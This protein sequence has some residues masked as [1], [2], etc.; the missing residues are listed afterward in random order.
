MPLDS[1]LDTLTELARE[2]TDAAARML[3]HCNRQ[4]ET[5][6]QQLTSLR[7]YR[8][9]YLHRLQTAMQTGLAAADC[10]NY[11]R[12]IATLDAAI[13]E[14][15]Q[16]VLAA[17]QQLTTGRGQWCEARRKLNAFETLHTRAQQAMAQRQRLREQRA[18]DEAAARAYHERRMN[19]QAAL[20]A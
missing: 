18:S 16:V 6:S 5:A 20:A 4:R 2:A 8:Q 10:H 13:A 15:T 12:F 7:D 11:Q 9:D 17:E 19:T 1:P 14:Q 3:G